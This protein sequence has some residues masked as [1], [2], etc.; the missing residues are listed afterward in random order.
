M[1]TELEMKD[2]VVDKPLSNRDEPQQEEVQD[3]SKSATGT[4]SNA[5]GNSSLEFRKGQFFAKTSDQF[6]SKSNAE[7]DGKVF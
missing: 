1:N 4:M 2:N 5:N 3:L 6:K 7:L